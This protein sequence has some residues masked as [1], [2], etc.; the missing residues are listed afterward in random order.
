MA[1]TDTSGLE[2][3]DIIANSLYGDHARWIERITA[4]PFSHVGLIIK[5][6]PAQGI[7][8]YPPRVCI[9]P[10]REFASRGPPESL[11]VFR[12]GLTDPQKKHLQRI[13][14]RYLGMHYNDIYVDKG[15]GVYCSEL[16]HR[17]ILEATGIALGSYRELQHLNIAGAEQALDEYYLWS[18]PW[19]GKTI[20]PGSLLESAL[21]QPVAFHRLW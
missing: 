11:A 5:T 7:E 4:S 16:V 19:E 15:E 1:H 9:T 18:V 10:L 21:L 6:D 13:A 2:I 8:A 3:G 14:P 12:L 17:I 20:T